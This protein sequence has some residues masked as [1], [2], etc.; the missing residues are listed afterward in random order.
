MTPQHHPDLRPDTTPRPADRR[1]RGVILLFVVV[2]LTLLAVLGSAYLVSSRIDAGTASPAARGATAD[3]YN[4][5]LADPVQ[6]LSDQLATAAQRTIFLDVFETTR[7]N[8]TAASARLITR[9]LWRPDRQL[10][11][12][13]PTVGGVLGVNPAVYSPMYAFGGTAAFGPVVP[14]TSGPQPSNYANATVPLR[15]PYYHLDAEGGTDPWL[16][17]RTAW[18]NNATPA[19]APLNDVV[20]PWISAPL[21]GLPQFN[22]DNVFFDPINVTLPINFDAAA[23]NDALRS[24]LVPTAT[25]PQ[26]SLSPNDVQS[27]TGAPYFYND[28]TRVYPA[29]GFAGTTTFFTAGDADGDGVADCGLVPIAFSNAPLPNNPSAAVLRGRYTDPETG[30]VYLVGVRIVD[31]NAAVNINTALSSFGDIPLTTGGFD[32][33]EDGIRPDGKA[34]SVAPFDYE[35]N[36]VAPN[37]GIYPTNIGLREMFTFD[38]DSAAGGMFNG[39]GTATVPANGNGNA[40]PDGNGYGDNNTGRTRNYQFLHLIPSRLGSQSYLPVTDGTTYAYKVP[41]PNGAAPSPPFPTYSTTPRPDTFYATLGELVAMNQTR[42]LRPDSADEKMLPIVGYDYTNGLVGTPAAPFRGRDEEAALVFH[43]GGWLRPG[44]PMTRAEQAATDALVTSAGNSVPNP[45]MA[46]DAMPISP[47]LGTGATATT[48]A[49]SEIGQRATWAALFQ[50]ADPDAQTFFGRL[51]GSAAYPVVPAGPGVTDFRGKSRTG[52]LGTGAGDFPASPRPGLVA[53]NGVSQAAVP[54]VLPID[55]TVAPAE[56]TDDLTRL[57]SVPFG[58]PRY[59]ANALVARVR[60]NVVPPVKASANTSQFNELWR[61]Y[62]NVMVAAAP[63]VSA[64]GFDAPAAPGT[65]TADVFDVGTG[66]TG[67]QSHSGAVLTREQVLLLR[68][69][70]AAVNT[71]DLRDVDRV[72][73]NTPPPLTGYPASITPAV[74]A[75]GDGYPDGYAAGSPD[76]GDNDITVAEVSLGTDGAGVETVAR[77]YGTEAQPFIDEL[78]VETDGAGGVTYAAVE[79]MNPYPFPIRIENWRL[80]AVNRSGAAPTLVTLATFNAATGSTFLEIPAANVVTGTPGYLF[81]NAGPAPVGLTPPTSA[82]KTDSLVVAGDDFVAPADFT[83][84][85]L[86]GATDLREIVLVRPPRNDVPIA[87]YAADDYVP[88]DAV[89]LRGINP[90]NAGGGQRFRFTRPTGPSDAVATPPGTLTYSIRDW[91]YVWAGTYVVGGGLPN[92]RDVEEFAALADGYNGQFYN[93]AGSTPTGTKPEA[94]DPLTMAPAATVA[95]GPKVQVGPVLAGPWRAPG[96]ARPTYPYGGFARDGDVLGVPLVGG[97]RLATVTGGV[98]TLVDFVALDLDL[99]FAHA[100]TAQAGSGGHFYEHAVAAAPDNWASDFFDYFAALNTPGED[101]FPQADSRYEN[102]GTAGVPFYGDLTLYARNN[103]NLTGAAPVWTSADGLAT[104]SGSTNPV[105]ILR[106]F[107]APPAG[108]PQP[109][110]GFNIGKNDYAEAFTPVEGLINLNTAPTGILKALPLAVDTT[111]GSPTLGNLSAAANSTAATN[112]FAARVI[113]TNRFDGGAADGGT[114][115]GVQSTGGPLTSLFTLPEIKTAPF[116]DT[117]QAQQ[118]AAGDISGR[119]QVD[120]AV[121]NDGANFYDVPATAAGGD[122]ERFTQQ[123]TR[124]SNLTT[125]RSDSF[126]VYLVVQAW[127]LPDT[128]V[129]PNTPARLMRQQRTAFTV[130]RSGV[131]PFKPR[132]L[133]ANPQTDPDAQWNV[134]DVNGEGFKK[135]LRVTPVP[136]K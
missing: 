14:G 54:K 92:S 76:P 75:D 64:A 33:A 120:G 89:D 71:M 106:F 45:E 114:A 58:M 135:A 79:L 63:G 125:T 39:A 93:A 87:T 30:L 117:A 38:V 60:P 17:A 59:S 6:V 62:F 81:V 88:L 20:W 1:R 80:A 99:A 95:P 77:V 37:W 19:G 97:Y 69:A 41:T 24:G 122:F 129:T 36:F 61:A 107:A 104:F 130:D 40:V 10:A 100:D 124:L 65:G 43:G 116:N 31:N 25:P 126:T 22:V 9:L 21:A 57:S 47:D 103:G 3:T 49:D 110:D 66:G 7:G 8:P 83:A 82:V 73:G 55:P 34:N 12:G 42:L 68:A 84:D 11:G 112:L 102:T 26:G 5:R 109:F 72:Y 121:L 56:T 78:M 18:F 16:A 29:L 50:F 111:A 48:S 132:E 28:R 96:H 128:T 131:L 108:L 44:Q 123:L 70:V 27:L 90:S 115:T 85:L 53:R 134:A 74:D 118:P 86:E 51:P 32:L 136:T 91:D 101:R 23:A 98:D 119:L 127:Q 52:A 105:G 133:L 15:F 2:L 46:F 67:L 13:P 35:N 113:G 4:P 94:A